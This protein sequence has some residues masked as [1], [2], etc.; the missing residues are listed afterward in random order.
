MYGK[1]GQICSHTGHTQM[2][3]WTAH[4]WTYH[5][6]GHI[7]F[8]DADLAWIPVMP[9]ACLWLYSL[10]GRVASCKC[11]QHRKEIRERPV[12]SCTLCHIG[13]QIS[14]KKNGDPCWQPLWGSRH[15]AE[16]LLLTAHP[17]PSPVGETYKP[18]F[19]NGV[20]YKRLLLFVTVCMS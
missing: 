7:S 13:S 5:W 11:C 20:Q 2:L 9:G 14:I 8:A 19:I 12:I 15:I 18:N 3:Y 17:W 16:V 4:K 6:W 1:C 10:S